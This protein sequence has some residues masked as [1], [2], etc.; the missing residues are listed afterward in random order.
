MA[1]EKQSPIGIIVVVAVIAVVAG[2]FLFKGGGNGDQNAGN[3]QQPTNGSDTN[4]TTPPPSSQKKA[5]K[6]D[7][8]QTTPPQDPL[9]P[10]KPAE[11][12]EP[13]FVK[14]GLVA[15]YPFNGN[16]ND[17]SGKGNGG[18]NKGATPAEDRHGKPNS[19]LT[20]DG[21]DDYLRIP[22]DPSLNLKKGLTLA[23]WIA[24]DG[25]K[26]GNT[27]LAKGDTYS[28]TIDWHF[29]AIEGK[30][31]YDWRPMQQS[32]RGVYTADN[33]IPKG[34]RMHVMATHVSGSQP[35]LYINGVKQKVTTDGDQTS[36]RHQYKAPI[37]IGM[38]NRPA[39]QDRVYFAGSI[40]DV[41]IYNRAL[42]EEQVKALYD[43]EKPKE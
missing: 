41:R 16:A 34:Q 36:P 39:E 23:A 21:K 6:S 12:K 3:Q 22:D 42:T 33:T 9:K 40:D 7:T 17:E 8:N 38:N 18:I 24:V 25:D 13:A 19:S 28:N 4:E 26:I 30:L 27:I 11:P 43:W 10:E 32:N 29:A 15:Y 14:E 1:E 35:V 37:T 5:N 20:F 2:I 31:F